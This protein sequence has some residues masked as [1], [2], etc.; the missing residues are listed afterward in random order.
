MGEWLSS[1]GVAFRCIEYT[2]IE[3]ENSR[4]ISF[5]VAFDR[6]PI[7]IFSLLFENR[8]RQP[9]YFWHNIGKASD[10]WWEYLV[11]T[12]QITTG[13]ECQPGDQGE[14][15]LRGFIKSDTVVAYSRR[16][17]AIGWGIISAPDSYRLLQPGCKDDR[18]NGEHLHRLNIDWKYTVDKLENAIAPALLLE[19]Y[20]IFHPRS[21]SVSID[22]QK[23]KRMIAD[24]QNISR[25]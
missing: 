24:M 4:F 3:H 20:G 12:G 21:T 8:M 25:E 15:I 22:P 14:K 7:A 11:Q 2:P 18:L 23:A 19:K 9:G 6:S 1:R 13:F 16:F 17:G 5:S 10:E